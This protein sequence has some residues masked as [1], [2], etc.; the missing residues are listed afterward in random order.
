MQRHS[1]E[2][3]ADWRAKVEALGLTYHTTDAPYWDESAYYSFSMAE[4]LE[5]ERSTGELFGLCCQAVEHVLK[6]D[7]WE[8]FGIDRSLAPAIRRSWIEDDVSLYG[9]FDLGLDADG[10]PKMYEFNADTPT[11]L[12]EAAVIQWYWLQ[13]RFPDCDQ[14]N[15][16]HERLVAQWK[17]SELQGPVHFACCRNSDEEWA[18]TIYMEDTAMQAGFQTHRLFMDEIGWKGDRFVDMQNRPIRTLFKLY[19]W[20]WM[21]R[22]PFGRHLSK[23]PWQLIEP[24]WKMIL[25][26]KR[27]LPLLWELF[28]GHR[29]LL[30]AYPSPEKL[31]NSWIKKPVFGRGGVGMTLREPPR[32]LTTAGS[33]EV[34]G[35]SIYQALLKPPCIDGRYPVLGSWIIGDAP[36]GM[37]LREANSPITTEASRFV[38]HRITP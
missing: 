31:G 9:R 2:P 7:R 27:I 6:T 25:S 19:P 8:E 5:I 36:A 11:S 28:P 33:P 23:E 12:L 30:P 3:R 38:P 37:G 26:N 20:E 13:E 21:M 24:A 14:F 18:T 4:I 16:I 1:I 15:S 17:I 34:D 10:V 22:E 29:N 32:E 35:G